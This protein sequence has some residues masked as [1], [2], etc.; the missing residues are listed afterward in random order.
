MQLGIFAKTFLRPAFGAVLDAAVAQGLHLIQFNFSCVD[1]PPMP[2]VIALEV[3]RQV[4]RECELR[5]VSVVGVSGTFNMAHP[6]L[7]QREDGLRRLSVLAPAVRALGCNFISL[8]TGTR[9]PQDMWR[10]HP[11][12]N[13]PEAGRDLRMT[14]EQ[15]VAIADEHDVLLGIE[16]ETGNVVGSARKARQLLDEM[17]SPWLKIILDPANLFH[18]GHTERMH[19]TIA[20]AVQLLG[21]D[22]HMAHAKELAADGSMANLAPGRGVIDWAFYFQ[23]LREV[24]FS[25][26]VVMHGLTES[27]VAPAVAFLKRF[28]S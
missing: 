21:P 7:A 22:I 6:E 20:E 26:P 13:S 18:A 28:V 15:A 2:D 9:D 17:K 16:P 1:L 4:R 3:A 14:M 19:E 23:C 24:N 10:A 5:S 8:C 11:E 25:G 12:N 27:D